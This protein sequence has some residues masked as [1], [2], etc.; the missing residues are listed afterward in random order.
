MLAHLFM[1]QQTTHMLLPL[2]PLPTSGLIQ[3]EARLPVVQHPSSTSFKAAAK[4]ICDADDLK[5]F[6]TSQTARDFV[7]F[8]LTLNSAVGGEGEGVSVG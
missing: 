4:A 2:S 8:I 5:A 6:L 7:G 3:A 1:K